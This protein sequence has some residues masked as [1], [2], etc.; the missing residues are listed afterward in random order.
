MRFFKNFCRRG[1]NLN[2]P[3]QNVEFFFGEKNNYHQ[4]GKSYLEFDKTVRNPATN[5]DNTSQIIFLN[6]SFAHCFK[7]ASVA[8]TGGMEI[9]HVKLLGQISTIMRSLTSK[10]GDL[11]SQF[12][13]INEWNTA[14][15]F[16]CTPF[17]QMLIDNHTVEANKSK[18]KGQLPLEHNFGFS[19]TF[20]KNTRNPG[21]HQTLKT[22]DLQYNIF[23]TK[24]TDNNVTFN[25]LYLVVLIFIPNTETQ[26]LFNESIKN[27]Y[28]I[29]YD[30]CIQ[31]ENFLLMVMNLKS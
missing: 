8:T 4:C 1:A 19:E 13:N 14:V 10:D 22:N 7:E 28:T 21:F 29:T 3:D 20:K 30:S 17:K 9:E 15:D 31:N 18:I 6:K 25:S 16:S 5:F 12:D 23:T 26:A 27:I 11:L 24:A 2:D